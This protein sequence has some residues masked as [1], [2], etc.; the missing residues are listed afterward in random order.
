[1]AKNILIV[2][3]VI[4]W[5]RTSPPWGCANN[6][7]LK[8]AQFMCGELLKTW[9]FST[10]AVANT[11]SPA[12]SVLVTV[13]LEVVPGEAMDALVRRCAR[14]VAIGWRRTAQHSLGRLLP[15]QPSVVLG[16]HDP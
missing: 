8:Y 7:S 15:A 1:M 14:L 6:P 13:M 5:S 4:R 2:Q 3:E 11:T 10:R 9:C 16:V 12:G